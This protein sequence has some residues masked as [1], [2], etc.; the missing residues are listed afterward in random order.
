[1]TETADLHDSTES[2]FNV[3]GETVQFRIVRGKKDC[4]LSCKSVGVIWYERECMF[5]ENLTGS[6][7]VL[8]SF[9]TYHQ[10]LARVTQLMLLVEQELLALPEHLTEFTPGF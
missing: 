2:L 9:M 10:F 3:Q 7:P 6:I 1:M 5:R 4:C 8:S